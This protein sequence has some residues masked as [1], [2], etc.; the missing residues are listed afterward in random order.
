[1]TVQELKDQLENFAPD[2]TV[3]FGYGYGDHGRTQVA[4]RVRKVDDALVCWSEY[5]QMDR[6]V[7]DEDEDAE[8]VT[9]AQEVVLIA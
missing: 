7:D 4:A 3:R 8:E 5:H 6:V 2:T 9:D 1:M